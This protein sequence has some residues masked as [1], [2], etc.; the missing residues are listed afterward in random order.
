[1][2]D[3]ADADIVAA[4][5]VDILNL[6]AGPGSTPQDLLVALVAKLSDSELSALE[7]GGRRE[8]AGG[9]CRACQ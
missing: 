6:N 7:S 3:A 9:C 2:C 8:L 5:K 4:D 1:M